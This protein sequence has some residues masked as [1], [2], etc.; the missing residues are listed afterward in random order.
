[1]VVAPEG[2]ARPGLPW[3][4]GTGKSIP[5]PEGSLGSR[6][7]TRAAQTEAEEAISGSPPAAPYTAP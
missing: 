3:Q 1:M 4:G 7:A 6:T 5:E 2:C